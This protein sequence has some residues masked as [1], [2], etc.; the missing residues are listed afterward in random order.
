MDSPTIGMI[1]VPPPRTH[2][3]WLVHTLVPSYTARGT[4]NS[5]A[6]TGAQAGQIVRVHEWLHLK[7]EKGQ[8][9]TRFSFRAHLGEVCEPLID[10]RAFWI[11]CEQA[12]GAQPC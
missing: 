5:T 6:R 9:R 3:V 7:F 4:K 11:R 10:T 1:E 8:A 12:E 2:L